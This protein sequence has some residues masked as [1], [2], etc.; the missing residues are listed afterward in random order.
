MKLS[1]TPAFRWGGRPG[2]YKDF[3]GAVSRACDPYSF[4]PLSFHEEIEMTAWQW[5][6]FRPEV[7][8]I[9]CR[10]TRVQAKIDGKAIEAEATFTALLRDGQRQYHLVCRGEP[11]GPNW[12]ALG[13]IARHNGAVIEAHDRVTLRADTK[14]NARLVRLMQ[15]SVIHLRDGPAADPLIVAAVRDGRTCRSELI[16]HLREVSSQLIDGRAAQLHCAGV[17][18]LDLGGDDYG[19]SVRG[20]HHG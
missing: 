10:P 12:R 17:L 7:K 18:Q 2:R 20:G 15:A 9:T 8:S 5:V 6:R 19:V 13:Q 3:P 1:E 16:V 11:S 4:S 14:R